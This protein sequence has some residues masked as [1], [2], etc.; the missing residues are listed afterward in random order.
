MPIFR[1]YSCFGGTVLIPQGTYSIPLRLGYTTHLLCILGAE[2]K[3]MHPGLY[4]QRSCKEDVKEHKVQSTSTPPVSEAGMLYPLLGSPPLQFLCTAGVLHDVSL[5]T[6]PHH[7]HF[8]MCI[9]DAIP[10]HFLPPATSP[11]HSAGNQV[12]CSPFY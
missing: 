11:F 2:K 10:L 9:R 7:V 6:L 4:V 3:C 8:I 1:L 12:A 5:N